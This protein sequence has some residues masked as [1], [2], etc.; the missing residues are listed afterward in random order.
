V[1]WESLASLA[2]GGIASPRGG[3]YP[4]REM[5]RSLATV[6]VLTLSWSGAAHA[7]CRSTTCRGECPTDDNGCPSTG[8][9]LFW[10]RTCIG[11]SMQ[12][13]G[14]QS[15]GMKEA[16]FAIQKSF[17]AWSD[18]PCPNAD[19]KFATMTFTM[20]Q[21]VSCRKS[22]YNKD[23]GNVNVVIFKDD[24][25]TYKGIDGTLAKTSVTYDDRTGEIFDADIEINAAFNNLT[26]SDTDIGYDLQAI[27]THEVGHFIG[28]AHSPDPSASMYASYAQGTLGPRHLNEDDAAAVC[29]VYPPDRIGA[30]DPTPRGGLE[31]DCDDPAT[32]GCA[33]GRDAGAG[34]LGG[35]AIVA[36]IVLARTRRR[37]ARA[38]SLSSG[39]QP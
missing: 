36:A 9:K 6:L 5:I 31:P 8:Q 2:F 17:Q 34:E 21:D 16:R 12:K 25:W 22:Q 30:C 7:Y 35:V 28:M 39:G 4:A 13:N 14:T 37:N 27:V 33:V 15:L 18:V 24:D 29:A 10:P 1:L 3:L 32:K 38:P 23:G 19:N 26:V 20:M 11:Y